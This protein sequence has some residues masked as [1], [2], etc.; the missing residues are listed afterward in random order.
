MYHSD[1]IDTKALS[2]AMG[3]DVLLPFTK[4]SRSMMMAIREIE[5]WAK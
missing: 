3:T 2:E 4:V 5:G 1:T